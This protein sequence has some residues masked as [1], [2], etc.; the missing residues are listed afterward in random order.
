M[1]SC[2][3]CRCNKYLARMARGQLIMGG[4]TPLVATHLSTEMVSLL[5]IRRTHS[6]HLYI[7]TV[8]KEL[9]TAPRQ[10]LQGGL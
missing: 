7:D 4:H 9:V 8:H 2:I 5:S 1:P 3:P 6:P 10:I